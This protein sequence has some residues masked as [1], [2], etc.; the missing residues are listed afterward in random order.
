MRPLYSVMLALGTSLVGAL[1][2]CGSD[3]G[4]GGAAAEFMAS[5]PVTVSEPTP[6]GDCGV[7]PDKPESKGSETEPW[8]VVN[9]T[10]PDNM[11]AAW[12]QGPAVGHVASATFDGGATW[13][14]AVIPGISECS[15]GDYER[16]SDPWLAFAANGDLYTVALS[17]DLGESQRSAIQVSKSV[18][19]GRTWGAPIS[20]ADEVGEDKPSI[21]ADPED[22]CLVFVGWTR[23]MEVR[24]NDALL[25][26]RTT[27]CG[28]TW[29]EPEVLH[30]DRFSPHGFQ[31][32]VLPD[33]T[34]LA[35]FKT[36]IRGELYVKRS[37][38][39]GETWPDART[40]ITAT[41]R[42]PKPVTPDGAVAI[43]S[44]QDLFDVAVDRKTGYL[45]AVWEDLFGGAPLSSPMQVAFSSSSDG[46][47]TW[48][49]PIR[50]DRTP[51][52]TPFPLEQA[53]TPS[54]EISDDGTI[55]VTYYNFENDMPDQ[56]PSWSDR[57]FVHCHPELADCNDPSNW[58]DALRLTPDSF[59]YLK[60]PFT[61][62][63]LNQ[64]LFLGDYVGL[65]S[66]GSDF[67]A[68]FSVTTGDDPADVIFVPIRAG[69]DRQGR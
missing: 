18:D 20:I 50:V 12:I 26:S 53:F 15:D 21:T 32:V 46:G 45:T 11:V 54:V 47:L 65:T 8:I 64:G 19:G 10:N 28:E 42:S 31:L 51:T 2:G 17:L 29:T 62:L 44:S 59:D 1:S 7:I 39:R 60:A 48:S 30:S 56:P 4:G 16:A 22:P 37:T 66:F 35:F 13:E 9:P 38:D 3:A 49:D 14:S 27:D 5:E 33:G 36:L 58:S 52:N 23:F 25:L 63:T 55:G 43:R 24:G 68:L 61:D 6:F 69:G 34:A 67:F 40:L 41:G 57:W